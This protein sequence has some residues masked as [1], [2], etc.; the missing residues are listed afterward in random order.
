VRVA[1][2]IVYVCATIVVSQLTP[3]VHRVFSKPNNALCIGV[4]N[5]TADKHVTPF[6]G[7]VYLEN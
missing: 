3:P 7:D 2:F 1:L 4:T 6:D 5:H